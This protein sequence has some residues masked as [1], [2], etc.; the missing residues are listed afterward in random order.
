[1]SNQRA[2]SDAQIRTLLQQKAALE[3]Q[4]RS[5]GHRPT[6]SAPAFGVPFAAG[7]APP[8]PPSGA[9][10]YT[11]PS[12]PSGGFGA[13]G[14]VPPGGGG[15]GASGGVPAGT[16]SRESTGRSWPPLEE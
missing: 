14:G 6:T 15:F 5:A 1:M 9:A 4:L 2:R 8:A 11:S 3:S 16:A 12:P 7:Y 13:G 10:G